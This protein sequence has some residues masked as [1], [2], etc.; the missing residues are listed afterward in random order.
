MKQIFNLSTFSHFLICSLILILSS[1]SVFAES[2]KINTE[3]KVDALNSNQPSPNI[4]SNLNLSLLQTNGLSR[5]DP[6]K[7]PEYLVI[8]I[9]QKIAQG[10]SPVES[11]I[12][13]SIEP[14]RRWPLGT[15]Q[16]VGII[17]DVKKPKA[18]F[19]DKLNNMHVL[20]AHDFIGN[21]K[22]VITGIQSGSV[23]VLEG[24]I[25][26]VIKIKK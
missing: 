14:I 22:G 17:W 5:R 24:K 21:A 20:V 3:N 16:L 9:R 19:I 13:E 8:K 2:K 7:L 4:N 6:F 23:I 1:K 18:M 11:T 15:Y 12:D 26:Q 10:V 25:P